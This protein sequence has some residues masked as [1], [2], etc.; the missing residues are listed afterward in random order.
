LICTLD[1]YDYFCL[2]DNLEEAG[3]IFDYLKKYGTEKARSLLV[4]CIGQIAD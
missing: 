2:K 4:H 3:K 1:I